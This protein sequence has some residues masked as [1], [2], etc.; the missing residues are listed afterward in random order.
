M[1]S[2]TMGQP[3]RGD[4]GPH[5]SPSAL[6]SQGHLLAPLF[7]DLGRGSPACPPTPAPFLALTLAFL[8]LAVRMEGSP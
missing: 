5:L 4:L 2:P 7:R 1:I 6:P 8:A 3:P